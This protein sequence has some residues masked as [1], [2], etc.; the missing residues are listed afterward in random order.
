M[1][2][3]AFQQLDIAQDMES[4]AMKGEAYLHLAWGNERL[5]DYHKVLCLFH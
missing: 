4:P 2:D 5:G 3:F 1:L